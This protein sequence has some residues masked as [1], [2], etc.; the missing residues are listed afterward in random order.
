MKYLTSVL[1]TVTVLI[2]AG[3]CVQS[4]NDPVIKEWTK[5][6]DGK[7]VHYMTIDGV[8]VH[9]KDPKKQPLPP[10][11]EPGTCSTQEKAGKAPSDAIVLFDGTE[12]AFKD[13]WE[14]ARKD[15]KGRWQFADGYF[16]P[17]KRSGY[18]QTKKKFGSC[19][20]HLEFA[21][22]EKVKGS[23]QGRGN[24]GVFLMGTYEVQI[25]DSY[26]NTTYADGQL[27]ALYGRSKPL[28][29]PARKPGQWQTYDIIFHQPEFDKDGN[30]VKKATFTVLLNGVLI[31]D[32]VVL[33]GGT[34]WNGPHAA[35]HY[36]A[37]PDK[38]PLSLQDHGNPIKFRNIWIRELCD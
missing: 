5:I 19:Q 28:V 13:E 29:N 35:T 3:A 9:E 25:L 4:N 2:T 16:Y 34:G 21:T 17:Q 15:S 14:H 6:V 10:V 7:K 20:L 1:I 12:K 36:K 23:G 27:G 26:N 31:Q 8:M 33:S 30:V 22:P 24:S 38:L 11:V 32:H 18:L 37:H